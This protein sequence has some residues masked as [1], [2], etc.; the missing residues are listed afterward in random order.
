MENQAFM[1]KPRDSLT[2]SILNVESN[3]H[4]FYKKSTTL[5]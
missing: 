4:G 1:L 3:L 2:K 5:C